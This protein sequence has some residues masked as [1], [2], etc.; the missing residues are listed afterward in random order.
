[1]LKVILFICLCVSSGDFSEPKRPKLI[2]D[3]DAGGD[4]AMAIFLALLYEKHYNGPQLVGLT[5]ANGNTPENNVYYNNQ[6]ILRIANR[7]DVPIYRGS[8]SSLVTTPDAGAWF[9]EDGLGD[10]GFSFDDLTPAQDKTAVAALIELS[11]THKGDLTV[12]T[13]GT[14]TNVALAIKTDPE[15]LDR[16][17]HLY[18]AA[19]HIHDQEF[20]EAEFNAHMDV[21]A[22]H[23]VA[24]SANPDKV[25]FFPFSQVMTHLNISRSWREEVLGTIDTDIIRA[26]NKFESVSL[27]KSDQWDALDPAAI[28]VAV[29]PSLVSEY[30]YSKH[31]IHLCGDTRGITTN[32]FVDK[33][34]ANARIVYSVNQEE[35]KKLLLDL[36]SKN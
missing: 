8:K 31:G 13:I 15:F 7:Q 30:R 10:S 35:Y 16:L 22:Y 21:E 4:D 26:M 6:R 12:I 24:K 3:N 20:K 23:I 5:T 2:I 34:E 19:G 33:T 14:L 32:S 11:K 17:E 29:N 18:V 27:P 28:A 36:F 25:T 1:M 9:G